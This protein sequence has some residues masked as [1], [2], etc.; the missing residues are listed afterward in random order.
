MHILSG[1]SLSSFGRRKI[2]F[3]HSARSNIG[4]RPASA[5]T[6]RPVPSTLLRPRTAANRGHSR[7]PNRSTPSPTST[8]VGSH[9]GRQSPAAI[10]FESW[11]DMQGGTACCDS[12]TGIPTHAEVCNWTQWC[13]H[14]HITGIHCTISLQI[15]AKGISPSKLRQLLDCGGANLDPEFVFG[16]CLLTSK[17]T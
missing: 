8:T 14:A 4:Q 6:H 7:I 10:D 5:S 13:T 17:A 9:N 11:L 1:D 3:D 12:P 2:P 15:G 16:T